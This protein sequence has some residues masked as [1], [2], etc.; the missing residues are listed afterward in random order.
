[1]LFN[2]G[3]LDQ[4]CLC[5]GEFTIINQPRQGSERTGVLEIDSR[6][7][8]LFIKIHNRVSRWNPEIYALQNW[9]PSIEPFSPRLIEIIDYEDIKALVLSPIAGKTINESGLTDKELLIK[10]YQ[11]AGEIL[12]KL[13]SEHHGSYFGI[14]RIDGFPLEKNAYTNAGEYVISSIKKTFEHGLNAKI[15]TLDNEALVQWC[16]DN[17]DVFKHCVSVPTNWDY[18]PNN[19][20]IDTQGNFTGVID[21]EN[22]LWG[23]DFDS[24]GVIIERYT[25]DQPHL[26]QA[27]FNG[28]GFEN[29]LEN[30]IRLN[31][32]EIKMA[33]ADIIVG[34]ENNLKRNYEFGK[35]LLNQVAS[36][37]SANRL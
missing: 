9:M 3:L 11:R 6:Y 7:G 17:V 16:Q 12:R 37:I 24:F 23:V 25:H 34:Y 8:R 4:I 18:S 15:L 1:M 30:Q 13:H 5:I 26:L 29:S 10:A 22:M 28:Y 36:D 19:W 35:A 33:M 31:I 32:L 27:F 2:E 21:F 14:P 20:L